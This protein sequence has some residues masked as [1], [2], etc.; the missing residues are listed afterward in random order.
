M[1]KGTSREWLANNFGDHCIGTMEYWIYNLRKAL[2]NHP[3]IAGDIPNTIIET[4]TC[5]GMSAKM[6]SFQFNQVITIEAIPELR[7]TAMKQ[8]TDRSNIEFILGDAVA[9]LRAT[10]HQYEQ[11]I[12]FFLDSHFGLTSS[13]EGELRAIKDCYK[14]KDPIIVIDDS[15]NLGNGTFPS[16]DNLHQLVMEINPEY[17]LEFL[18]LGTGVCLCYP[19][20]T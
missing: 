4:G 17:I 16:V 9:T 6:W 13:L 11:R 10:L 12:V 1:I 5:H 14:R 19:P 8:N 7:E 20:K 3:N 2:V 18:P 15:Q